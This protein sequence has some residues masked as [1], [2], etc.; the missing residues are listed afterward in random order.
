M[1]VQQSTEQLLHNFKVFGPKRLGRWRTGPSSFAT[2]KIKMIDGRKL[3]AAQSPP[4]PLPAD[5][6]Y[7]AIRAQKAKG[8]RR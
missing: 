7:I 2:R 1:N 3:I 6:E 4:I 5:V 8:A